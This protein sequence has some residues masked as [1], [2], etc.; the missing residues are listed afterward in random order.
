M[1]DTALALDIAIGQ[2]GIVCGAVGLGGLALLDE[3]VVPE[4]GEDVLDDGSVL[5][6]G[7]A[8]KDV[9]VD[10][11]PVVDVLVD[12]VILGAQCGRIHSLGK[13]LCLCRSAVLIGPA[14]ID[15]WEAPCPAKARKDVG[16]LVGLV[17]D[18]KDWVEP[19]WSWSSR[20]VPR[21]WDEA[22]RVKFTK[23]LPMMLPR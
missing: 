4:A 8:A 12:R 2:E 20:G 1:A 3:A 16:R 14:D 23:T 21:G 11:E 13:R 6:G 22:G 7:G 9:E 5:G 19:P 10:P 17:S 18:S 15:G